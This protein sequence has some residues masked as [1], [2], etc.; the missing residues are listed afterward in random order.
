MRIFIICFA[1]FFCSSLYSQTPNYDKTTEG[2]IVFHAVRLDKEGKLIPWYSEDIGIAYD[3]V[4]NTVW[5]FWDTMRRD[6]NGLPYYMNHQVWRPVNDPRGAGG[7]QYAMA[8]SSWQ[9]LYQYS[10]NEKVKENMKFI[11]DYYLT[12]SLSSSTAKWPYLPYPYNTMQYSGF[13][14]GDMVIGKDYTQPDKAGSF[15]W[16][17]IKLYKIT[18]NNNYLQSAISIANTLAAHTIAGDYDHSPMPFKVNALTGQVGQLRSN[19]GN[20]KVDGASSYTSNWCGTLELFL[21]LQQLK[22]GEVAKYQSAFNK[23]LAWMKRYP[24]QNNRW[25]PFFEDIPGWSDTQINAVTFARFIMEHSDLFPDWKKQ[26]RGILD[27]VYQR[28]GNDQWKKIWSKG[29]E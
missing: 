26:V 8:L 1:F 7:D 23:I 25:G 5:N 3:F 29:C 11:A 27:W 2:F 19:S 9:L 14:D 6:M 13:Y 17:L 10:G 16:E 18:N 15:G 28:L 21:A 4:I 22:K 24:L 20:G 12:H